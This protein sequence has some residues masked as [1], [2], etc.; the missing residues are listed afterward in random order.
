MACV[1]QPRDSRAELLRLALEVELQRREHEQHCTVAEQEEAAPIR[2]TIYTVRGTSVSL[3]FI[4]ALADEH[5]EAGEPA[6]PPA[7]VRKKQ[8]PRLPMGLTK[9]AR[10]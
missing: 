9:A 3:P 5:P 8:E 7:P 10:R 6:P 2:R 1:L 4:E